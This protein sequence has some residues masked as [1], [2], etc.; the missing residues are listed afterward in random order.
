MSKSD[1]NSFFSLEEVNALIPKMEEHFQSFWNFRQN[2]QNI[3][4]ELRQK[5]KNPDPILPEEIAHNQVRQSQ[6]HFL[7]ECGKKELEAIMECGGTIK[8]LE[9]G[10]VDFPHMLEFEEEK[11]YLCWKFGEKKVRFWHGMN[12]SFSARKPLVRKV[13]H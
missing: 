6:V 4:E 5:A 12:E 8:D 1:S 10:L 7:L 13:H 9:I 2:A 11:V 3:L